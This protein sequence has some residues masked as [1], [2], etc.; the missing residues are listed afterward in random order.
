LDVLREFTALPTDVSLAEAL[1]GECLQSLGSTSEARSVLD[2]ALKQDAGS[3]ELLRA[4]AK[5]HAAENEPEASARLLEKALSLD[6][7]D[8][9]SRYQ[10]VQVYH[11]LG[12]KADA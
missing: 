4:R 1:R 5:L 7:P 10:L 9:V 3:P 6:R 11:G 8:Y 12:R 2:L